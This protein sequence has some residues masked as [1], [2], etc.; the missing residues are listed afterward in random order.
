MNS[1][2]CLLFY[3]ELFCDMFGSVL[4]CYELTHISWPSLTQLSRESYKSE[5]AVLPHWLCNQ[6][7][8]SGHM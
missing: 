4:E 8:P 3:M 7:H 6:N 5:H 1:V 2:K